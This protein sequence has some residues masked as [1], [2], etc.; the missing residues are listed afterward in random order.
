MTNVYNSAKVESVVA[1]S[2]SQLSTKKK[3]RLRDLIKYLCAKRNIPD[4]GLDRS[5]QFFFRKPS[6]GSE[7][8]I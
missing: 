3:V 4:F 6:N 1:L 8:V 7:A 2:E 5:T